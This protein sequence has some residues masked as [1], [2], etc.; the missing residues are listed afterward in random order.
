MHF[1]TAVED[2]RSSALHTVRTPIPAWKNYNG[3]PTGSYLGIIGVYLRVSL[4]LLCIVL[5]AVKFKLSRG[6][7]YLV[8]HDASRDAQGAVCPIG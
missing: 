6:G 1:E 5:H 8:P 3:C 4:R 2:D 7:P